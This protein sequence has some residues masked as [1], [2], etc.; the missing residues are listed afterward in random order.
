MSVVDGSGLDTQPEEL[1]SHLSGRD[2]YGSRKAN[3]IGTQAAARIGRVCY[4]LVGAAE[5]RQSSSIG[6]RS[7]AICEPTLKKTSAS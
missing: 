1:A 5:R 6:G 2:V 3:C 4:R 7:S